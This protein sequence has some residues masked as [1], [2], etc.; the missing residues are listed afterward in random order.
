MLRMLL[1]APCNNFESCIY[2]M[3]VWCNLC[4]KLNLRI[5]RMLCLTVA[6]YATKLTQL[7]TWHYESYLY[8]LQTFEHEQIYNFQIMSSIFH[9]CSRNIIILRLLNCI[10]YHFSP[11]NQKMF[12]YLFLVVS[13]ALVNFVPVSVLKVFTVCQN[14]VLFVSI[15][16]VI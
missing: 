7:L 1:H 4:W 9:Y 5:Q 3:C 13:V 6:N 8:H 16:L 11:H 14:I 12:T 2:F 10:P 15:N